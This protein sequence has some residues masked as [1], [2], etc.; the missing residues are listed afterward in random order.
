MNWLW[1]PLFALFLL[2]NIYRVRECGEEE[3]RVNLFRFKVEEGGDGFAVARHLRVIAS[4]FFFCFTFVADLVCF[5]V[6]DGSRERL[7]LLVTDDVD[8]I[9]CS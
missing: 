3:E 1:G 8:S 9:N 5:E 4:C 7:S 6:N 2:A